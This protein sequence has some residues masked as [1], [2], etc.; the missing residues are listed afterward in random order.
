MSVNATAGDQRRDPAKSTDIDAN[1]RAGGNV[2]ARDASGAGVDIDEA[3]RRRGR[4][5]LL[6]LIA[7]CVAPVIASYIAFYFMPPQGRTNYGELV[8]PQRDLRSLP[9]TVVVAG[10]DS[11]TNTGVLASASQSETLGQ[12]R[13]RWLMIY[14]GPADCDARCV[15]RLYKMRQVRLTQGKNRDR[16]E[17]VWLLTGTGAPSTSILQSHEGMTVVRVDGETL[18]DALPPAAGGV[19]SDHIYLVDPLGNLMMRFPSDADP[20]RMKKDFTRLLKASRIG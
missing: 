2:V 8:E 19:F 7:V 16:I 13:G 12:W 15:E 5:I 4:R 6:L 1:A 11:S 14:A 18:R 10:N 9:V 17:R 3:S 20:S